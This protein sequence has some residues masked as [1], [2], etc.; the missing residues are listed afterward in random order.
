MSGPFNVHRARKRPVINITPLI[1]VMF[2]LLI[3]FMVSSTFRDDFAVDVTLPEA[4][5]AEQM[6]SSDHVIAVDAEGALFFGGEPVD[7]AG[8]DQAIRQTLAEDP[9]VSLVLKADE[10]A[11]FGD[12]MKAI[13][14]ARGAGGSRL[15]LPARLRDAA[16]S[17]SPQ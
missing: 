10:D 8:L 7:E 2:L 1:D 12:V 4:A 6:E 9:E 16:E 17:L 14:T 13:D 3:F 15:I 5:T 11:G